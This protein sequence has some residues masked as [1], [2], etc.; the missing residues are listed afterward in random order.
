MHSVLVCL[1]L[2]TTLKDLFGNNF[3]TNEAREEPPR[4]PE[5]R[6][7]DGSE[8]FS[9]ME[10]EKALGMAEEELDVQAAH[11][12]RAEAAAELAEF[13]ESIPLD[14]DSRDNE[15]KSQAEEELDKLMDQAGFL[16][17]VREGE[18]RGLE[19]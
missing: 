19:D 7:P 13:D 11:T 1:H 18:G 15:E 14:T 17:G 2:Q 3:D 4:P 6:A 12:A 8:K 16:T 5:E 10:F 9:A